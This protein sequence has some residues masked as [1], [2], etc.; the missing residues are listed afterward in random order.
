MGLGDR[1]V[2]TRD[3]LSM[4]PTTGLSNRE[5]TVRGRIGEGLFPG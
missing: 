4:Y 3:R 5:G 2:T 1:A